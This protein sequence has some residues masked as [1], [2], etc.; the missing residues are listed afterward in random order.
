MSV[1]Q[2]IAGGKTLLG[3]RL[4]MGHSLCYSFVSASGFVFITIGAAL[5]ERLYGMS[6]A[7]FGLMWSGLAVS[8]ILGASTAGA[9][10]RSR[11]PVKTQQLGMACNILATTLFVAA[12]FSAQPA[13]WLFSGSLALLMFANGVISPIALTGAVADY[14]DLAGVASGLS[15]SLAM[16]ISMFSAVTT[17]FVYDGTA[18]GCALLMASACLASWLAMRLA[19]KARAPMQEAN[20]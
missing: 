10:A 19:L 7:D 3:E 4:F 14:P 13:F 20:T 8:Y 5:Y 9:L 18:R 11:G 17:G 2:L 1:R 6:S 16:L 12:A 15:S